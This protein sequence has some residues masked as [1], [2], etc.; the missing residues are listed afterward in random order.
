MVDGF[1][2]TIFDGGVAFVI[3][4]SALLAY[5]RGFVR[6]TMSIA[7]WTAAVVLAFAFAKDASPLVK[8]IPY[9]GPRI[10]ADNCELSAI[11]AF[12][13][14]LVVSLVVVSFFTPVLSGIVQRSFLGGL[15]QGMG[16]LFGALRGV[17]LITAA[18]LAFETVV[19]AETMPMITES[20]SSEVFKRLRDNI[21]EEVPPDLP[22]KITALYGDLVGDCA[23]PA[24]GDDV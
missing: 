17:I 21:K 9:I 20:R 14:V 12:A 1:S 3:A 16:L 6:E 19:A 2:F 8:E 15:D 18:F 22:D 10:L 24:T 5:S 13:A 11:A 4:V 7:G 23:A